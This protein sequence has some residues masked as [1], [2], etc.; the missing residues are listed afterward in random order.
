VKTKV[1][2]KAAVATV[3]LMVG[4]FVYLGSLIW[5]GV[6]YFDGDGTAAVIVGGTLGIAVAGVVLL[7]AAVGLSVWWD[8]LYPKMQKFFAERE[9][10]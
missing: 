6:H 3:V 9:S 5:A 10:A 4:P 1:E 2:K 7:F 8:S